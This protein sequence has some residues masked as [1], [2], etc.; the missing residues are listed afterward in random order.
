[1]AIVD[2]RGGVD[3]KAPALGTVYPLVTAVQ[4]AVLQREILVTVL[5]EIAN[6]VIVHAIIVGHMVIVIV[7]ILTQNQL[8]G[9]GTGPQGA[10][11][12]VAVLIYFMQIA[13]IH[14]MHLSNHLPEAVVNAVQLAKL[15]DAPLLA[16]LGI[17]R[18]QDLLLQKWVL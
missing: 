9:A 13:T 14:V 6:M 8:A 11:G 12:V 4:I 18:D 17:W 7:A 10:A 15:R 3:D 2:I 16:I 5:S 1:M